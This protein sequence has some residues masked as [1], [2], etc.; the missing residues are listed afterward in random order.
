MQEAP[1]NECLDKDCIKK[2]LVLVREADNAAVKQNCAIF[3]GKLVKANPR[4]V[5]I[6]TRVESHCLPT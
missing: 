3:I 4:F 5:L 6:M 1:V 2:L